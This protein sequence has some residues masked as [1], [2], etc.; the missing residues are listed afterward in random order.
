MVD[1]NNGMGWIA[2][3]QRGIYMKMYVATTEYGNLLVGTEAETI[4]ECERRT[5]LYAGIRIKPD[6]DVWAGDLCLAEVENHG[7]FSDWP[8]RLQQDD[9]ASINWIKGCRSPLFVPAVKTTEVTK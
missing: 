4:E 7:L 9:Y 6:A 5:R 1:S 2:N 3:S 8:L